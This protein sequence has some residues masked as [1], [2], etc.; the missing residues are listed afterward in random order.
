MPNVSLYLSNVY[1]HH[2]NRNV[3]VEDEDGVCIS[4]IEHN[5]HLIASM[6]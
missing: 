2:L 3:M 6:S 1:L 5:K 4:S